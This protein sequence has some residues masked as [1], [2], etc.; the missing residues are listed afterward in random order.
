MVMDEK[1]KNSLKQVAQDAEAG[2]AKTLLRWKYRKEGKSP[3]Q[4]RRLD[5][6][7]QRVAERANEVVAKRGKTVWK[8]L[9]KVYFQDKKDREPDA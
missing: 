3:P 9:K 1:V 7:S 4:D 8:E 2:I 5:E 6:E